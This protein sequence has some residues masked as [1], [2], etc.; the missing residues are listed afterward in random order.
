M[1]RLR[2]SRVLCYLTCAD[3]PDGSIQNESSHQRGSAG[4]SGISWIH[5]GRNCK[6]VS[7]FTVMRPKAQFVKIKARHGQ[8]NQAK[9]DNHPPA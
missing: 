3:Q 7:H 5:R 6:I 1:G 9:P 8:T 4:K 2:L